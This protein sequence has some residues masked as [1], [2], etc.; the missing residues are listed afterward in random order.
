ML[1]STLNP[2]PFWA[3]SE[4]L[5]FDFISDER[6]R[7]TLSFRVQLADSPV[8]RTKAQQ[9]QAGGTEVGFYKHFNINFTARNLSRLRD[10][11]TR[12]PHRTLPWYD[13][14]KKGTYN[15]V[16]FNVAALADLSELSYATELCRQKGIPYWLLLQHGYEEFF[17]GSEEEMAVVTAVSTGAARFVFIAERNR[18][19][20]E[21]IYVQVTRPN[22]EEEV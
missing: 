21:D 1:F 9:L 14:I 15:L 3:G 17:C 5:W 20:L 7:N 10:K 12:K 8:T 16:W 2:Y 18:H 11:V 22:E 4:N 6:V 13:E 19:S